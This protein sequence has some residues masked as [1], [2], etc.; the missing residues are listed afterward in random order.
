MPMNYF[1]NKEREFLEKWLIWRQEE[2]IYKSTLNKPGHYLVL[3]KQKEIH[4]YLINNIKEG[5]LMSN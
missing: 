1:L 3:L 5:L 4:A 2:R